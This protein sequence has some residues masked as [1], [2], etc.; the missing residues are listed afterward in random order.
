MRWIG[1]AAFIVLFTV[2]SGASAASFDCSRARTKVEKLICADV[3]L[4][5]ADEEMAAAYDKARRS[6]AP[7]DARDLMLTQRSWLSS[8]DKACRSEDPDEKKSCKITYSLRQR[9]LDAW[10]ELGHAVMFD[11]S[12]ASK[13]VCGLLLA[14]SNIRVNPESSD[15]YEPVVAFVPDGFSEIDWEKLN[16]DQFAAVQIGRSRF[17]FLNQGAP[18][19]VYAIRA[20]F[21]TFQYYWFVVAAPNEADA[22]HKRVLELLHSH[23]ITDVENSFVADL[24]RPRIAGAR[25]VANPAVEPSARTP[26]FRSLLLDASN[27]E[28]YGGW[29]TRSKVLVFDGV[30]YLV[31]ASGGPDRPTVAVFR[32]N[33]DG[34]LTLLCSHRTLPQRTETYVAT[35][36][37]AACPVS[38]AASKINWSERS[39]DGIRTAVVDRPEWG[40]RRVVTEQ[41]HAFG[42][43][44]VLRLRVGPVGSDSADT[45]DLETFG[46][47]S[48]D[49]KLGWNLS[50]LLTDAGPYIVAGYWIQRWRDDDPWTGDRYYRVEGNKLVWACDSAFAVYPPPGYARF[51][52]Y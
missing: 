45:N 22:I 5:R 6:L 39:K 2:A 13:R 51:D 41:V 20:E 47:Y 26:T 23:P 36:T 29:Y 38:M 42:N 14:R 30:T 18:V 50:L 8:R 35:G 12:E 33:S 7:G 46:N 28:L 44:G 52:P 27:T 32:P 15:Y 31:A 11:S 19:D 25:A 49:W 9:D 43:E 3:E 21:R 24:T 17:D 16:V 34:D 1:P 10:P 4:S 48:E 40:G 37:D